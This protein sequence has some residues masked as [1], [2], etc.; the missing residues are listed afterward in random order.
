MRSTLV[1]FLKVGDVFAVNE[2]LRTTLVLLNICLTGKVFLTFF[3]EI[4]LSNL[5]ATIHYRRD[6]LHLLKKS[7]QITANREF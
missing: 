2:D 6:L 1:R 4:E 5:V 3:F 7:K